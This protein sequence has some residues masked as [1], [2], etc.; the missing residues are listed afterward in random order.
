[1]AEPQLGAGGRGA[2]LRVG[3]DGLDQVQADVGEPARLRAA[4]TVQVHAAVRVIRRED[5]AHP[6]PAAPLVGGEGQVE[7]APGPAVVGPCLTGPTGLV[8][9]LRPLALVVEVVAPQDPLVEARQLRG[10]AAA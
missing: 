7:G 4:A 10:D 2:Y 3:A 8:R 1:A 9:H 6:G 5:E